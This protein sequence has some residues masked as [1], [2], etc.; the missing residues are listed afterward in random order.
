MFSALGFTI[1]NWGSRH[2]K[3][4][5]QDIRPLGSMLSVVSAKN[6]PG[7]YNNLC[8]ITDGPVIRQLNMLNA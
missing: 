7:V 1:D 2:L 8:T 6:E 5:T 4:I 3:L